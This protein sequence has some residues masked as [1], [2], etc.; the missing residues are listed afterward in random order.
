LKFDP[1]AANVNGSDFKIHTNGCDIVAGK[2]VVS[3]PDKKGTLANTRI[4]NYQQLEQV[5]IVTVMSS[6]L[7]IFCNKFLTLSSMQLHLK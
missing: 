6:H 5:V 7:I 4:S 2:S 1:F 3:K